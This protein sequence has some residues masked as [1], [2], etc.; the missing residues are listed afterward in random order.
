MTAVDPELRTVPPPGVDDP[1]AVRPLTRICPYLAAAGGAWRSATAEREHRCG[2]VSPPAIL[3]AEK[4][5]RLCLTAD[6]PSCATFEAARAARPVVPVRAPTLPRPIARTT[7]VVLDHGRIAIAVPAIDAE[8][9]NGQAI[10]IALLALA[11]AAIVLARLTTGSAPAIV[12]VG[13]ASPQA[14]ARAIAAPSLAATA[15]KTPAPTVVPKAS[16]APAKA[17]A[18][19]AAPATPRPSATPVIRTYTVKAG[20]TLIAIAAKFGT[21]LQAIKRL[22]GISDPSTLRI[23]QILK[24]P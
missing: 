4:Q 19:P 17:K 6:F 8:R 11:F 22:N 14:S 21:K 18:S 1:A 9:S 10:L 24:I 15:R 7:P 12:S 20:D 3:A 2:A 16:A 5:R 13:S 23:G